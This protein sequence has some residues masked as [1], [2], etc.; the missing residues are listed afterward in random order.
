M[1]ALSLQSS[2]LSIQESCLTNIG[3]DLH[4]YY[5]FLAAYPDPNGLLKPLLSDLRELLTV[6]I[7]KPA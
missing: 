3:E 5:K 4:H 7:F 2:K 6:N 1:C